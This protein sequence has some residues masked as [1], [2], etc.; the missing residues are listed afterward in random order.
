MDNVLEAKKQMEDDPALKNNVNVNTSMFDIY[1]K[2]LESAI[3]NFL[4]RSREEGP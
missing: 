4:S 2:R 3:T 1:F